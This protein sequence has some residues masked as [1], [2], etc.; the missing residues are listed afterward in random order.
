MPEID[1]DLRTGDWRGWPKDSAVAAVV[2]AVPPI[3]RRK[4][5]Q[6]GLPRTEIDDVA[7]EVLLRAIASERS[8]LWIATAATP[9]LAW[10]NV[11]AD[12]VVQERVRFVARC[13]RDG[14]ADDLAST[15]ARRRAERS[16]RLGALLGRQ[17]KALTH[18]QRALLTLYLEGLSLD[19]L[20]QRLGC[21]RATVKD[22]LR[23]TTHKLTRPTTGASSEVAPVPRPDDPR[24]PPTARRPVR[25]ELALRATG[26]TYRQI[27]AQLGRSPGTVRASIRRARARLQRSV[28]P[29]PH[30]TNPGL[31]AMA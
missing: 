27:G 15:R 6:A 19:A 5:A 7:Q 21:T 25:A 22:R 3:A 29:P 24:L 23:R 4:V 12:R 14:S 31:F 9:V 26:L 28:P 17:E 30:V 11:T 20:A 2:D 10:L 18:D 13:R 1:P 16:R 8:G